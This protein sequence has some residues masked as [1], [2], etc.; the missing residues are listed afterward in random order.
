MLLGTLNKGGIGNGQTH[1]LIKGPLDVCACKDH[2]I[3]AVPIGPFTT[4]HFECSFLPMQK[5][6]WF[7]LHN[8][9]DAAFA[10]ANSQD[11]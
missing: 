6:M 8:L 9:A 3:L 5:T 7:V 4:L 10:Q 2:L 1:V 11:I